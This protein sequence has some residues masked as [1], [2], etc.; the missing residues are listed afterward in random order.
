MFTGDRSG[1]FLYRALWKTGFGNSPT[2]TDRYDGLVLTDCA[3]TAAL[4]C[5]PPANKP[6]HG[7][8]E[9]CAPW[10]EETIALVPARVFL[11]LGLIAWR[12]LS[13]LFSA[14]GWHEGRSPAFAHGAE[15]LLA[16]E[17]LLIASYHP[18]QRNTF[19]GRL[20]EGMLHE[21]FRRAKEFIGG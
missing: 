13:G 15:A 21:V 6:A 18:S 20:T 8:L 5:A 9:N 10:L 2:A 19:T 11:A 4:H 12:S 16:N 14:K 7:E 17:R 3:V 1:E